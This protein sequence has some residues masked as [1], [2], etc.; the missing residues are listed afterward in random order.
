[1][2]TK[3]WVYENWEGSYCVL[4]YKDTGKPSTEGDR[5]EL[6]N[7]EYQCKLGSP[8]GRPPHKEGSQG[9][10]WVHEWDSELLSLNGGD[11]EAS[12]KEFYP[13]VCGLEWITIRE[14][15]KRLGINPLVELMTTENANPPDEDVLIDEDE[16]PSHRAVAVGQAKTYR[17]LINN[18]GQAEVDE[19]PA[20][21]IVNDMDRNPLALGT[22]KAYWIGTD[23]MVIYMDPVVFHIGSVRYTQP[24]KGF[25]QPGPMY[26]DG[27]IFLGQ[28]QAGGAFEYMIKPRDCAIVLREPKGT[29]IGKILQEV[30][31][32]AEN[33]VGWYITF[34]SDH[35]FPGGY[36]LFIGCSEGEARGM[37][38]HMIGDKW[39]TSH[40]LNELADMLYKF[41]A[42]KCAR[43][44]HHH[45]IPGHLQDD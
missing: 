34:G 1:M 10:I 3:L 29:I 41:P 15:D 18:D 20:E 14:Q 6:T 8:M 36:I 27:I 4:V 28:M 45:E 30:N 11:W 39:C 22:H 42:S 16:M 25:I 35:I 37:M 12:T 24:Y 33:T 23:N 40:P 31:D 19:I 21:Q 38:C 7:S 5:F 17:D 9:K 32:A 43:V 44:I 26:P 13:C 2:G